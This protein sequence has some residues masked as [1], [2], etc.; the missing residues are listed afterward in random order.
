MLNNTNY[1]LI[2]EFFFM[3]Y[4]YYAK[5]NL[6]LS[7]KILSSFNITTIC[8]EEDLKNFF[9]KNYQDYLNKKISFLNFEFKILNKS[10]FK[11][12]IY[13]FGWYL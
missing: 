1:N 8:D 12:G 7:K 11:G 13:R 9:S 5:K 3:S 10:H 6:K 2:P 4:F